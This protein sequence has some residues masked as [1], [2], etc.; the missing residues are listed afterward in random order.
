MAAKYTTEYN[1]KQ[2]ALPDEFP[3]VVKWQSSI[4]RISPTLLK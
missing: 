3:N 4:H 2:Y 1:E